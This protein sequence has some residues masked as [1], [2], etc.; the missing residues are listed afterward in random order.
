VAVSGLCMGA[1]LALTLAAD[2]NVDVSAIIPLATTLKWD[3]WGIPWYRIFAPLAY[4]TPLRFL[5][6]FAERWPFGVKDE[7]LRAW[8][9]RQMRESGN[10]IAG[11]ARL[12]IANVYQALRMA[13]HARRGLRR[14]T[15]PALV[16]H[17]RED[18]VASPR[19]ARWVMEGLSS[20]DKRLILLDDSYHMVTIDREKERVAAE[21]IAF[22]GRV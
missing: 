13:R 10:S 11:A 8:I 2:P 6:S 20:R 14:I 22:L 16:I 15:A 7:R 19:N 4:Y 12:P 18:D 1:V 21:C 9:A 3:G 5:Y 17:A